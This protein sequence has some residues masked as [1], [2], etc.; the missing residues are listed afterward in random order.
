MTTV[1][2][3]GLIYKEAELFSAIGSIGQGIRHESN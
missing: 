2:E 3:R 1:K